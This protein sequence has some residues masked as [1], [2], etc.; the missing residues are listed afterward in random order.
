MKRHGRAMHRAIRR[1]WRRL[2]D[3]HPVEALRRLLQ[4]PEW[5]AAVGLPPDAEIDDAEFDRLR[6]AMDAPI[7]VTVIND[8]NGTYGDGTS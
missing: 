5:R 2:P 8:P 4:F 6:A 1:H 7:T 3:I